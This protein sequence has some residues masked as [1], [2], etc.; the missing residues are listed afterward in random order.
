M[1]YVP[2]STFPIT[3]NVTAQ[4]D[5]VSTSLQIEGRIPVSVGGPCSS[6]KRPARVTLR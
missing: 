1:M 2:S 3:A 4:S 5:A 6:V